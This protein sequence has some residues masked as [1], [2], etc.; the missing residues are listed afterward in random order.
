M[1]GKTSEMKPDKEEEEATTSKTMKPA[2]EE[3]EEPTTSKTTKPVKEEEATTSKTMKPVKEEVTKSKAKSI[4]KEATKKE[5]RASKADRWNARFEECKEYCKKF[6]N[7][8]IPTSYKENKALG[9]WVQENRRNFKLQKQ[10]MKPR[11]ELTDE[12]IEKLDEIGFHW[13][14]TPDPNRSA[15]TDASWDANFAKLLEYKESNGDFDIPM[16]E[17][18]KSVSELAKWA[19]VQRNQYNLRE[20]K[21]KS[22]MTKERVKKLEGIGFDWDGPR[23]L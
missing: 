4:K 20:T 19:R 17:S 6:G 12:Q 23:T 5:P 7:C 18:K 16:D 22:F 9:I 21:R 13:G 2:K 3:K 15:E 11:M 14:W 8:K 1:K 10:G